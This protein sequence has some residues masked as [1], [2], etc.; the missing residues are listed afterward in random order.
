MSDS[1]KSLQL[2]LKAMDSRIDSQEDISCPRGA[3]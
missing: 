3:Q 1:L 2:I